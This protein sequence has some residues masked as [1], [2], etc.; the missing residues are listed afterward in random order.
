MMERQC[1][2]SSAQQHLMSRT[3]FTNMAVKMI[4]LWKCSL[5]YSTWPMET[6]SENSDLIYPTLHK[7]CA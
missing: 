4:M 1:R 2:I 6:D 5:D 7:M 3:D